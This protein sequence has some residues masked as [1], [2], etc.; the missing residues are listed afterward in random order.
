M[1]LHLATCTSKDFAGYKNIPKGNVEKPFSRNY[2][3]ERGNDWINQMKSRPLYNGYGDYD[4]D[5]FKTGNDRIDDRNLDE[6][7]LYYDIELSDYEGSDII[8]NDSN[9]LVSENAAIAS[10]LRSQSSSPEIME[11]S[12]ASKTRQHEVWSQIDEFNAY[13]SSHIFQR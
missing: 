13:K 4:E 12:V 5:V 8:M 1:L 7:S 6:T 2:N 9:I 3:G 11:S 10:I